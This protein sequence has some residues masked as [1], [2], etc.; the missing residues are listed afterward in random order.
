MCY[1]PKGGLFPFIKKFPKP[2]EL[3]VTPICKEQFNVSELLEAAS[4]LHILEVSGSNDLY[5]NHQ[6]EDLKKPKVY[7]NLNS[8]NL[9]IGQITAN[10]LVYIME[11]AKHANVLNFNIEGVL[12]EVMY[13]TAGKEKFEINY[14]FGRYKRSVSQEGDAMKRMS[15]RRI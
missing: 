1:L 5:S 12:G 13:Y 2:T 7:L 3:T 14:R 4:N 9:T 15:L 11:Q 8:L 6:K 10:D